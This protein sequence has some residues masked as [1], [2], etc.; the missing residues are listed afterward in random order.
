MSNATRDWWR[1]RATQAAQHA[2]TCDLSLTPVELGNPCGSYA[3]LSLAGMDGEPIRARLVKPAGEGPHPVILMFHDANRGVRGWHHMTRF[4]ALGY[5]VAALQNRAG[6]KDVLAPEPLAVGDGLGV[7]MRVP[8]CPEPIPVGRELAPAAADAFEATLDDALV[9]AGVLS[10]LEGF[11]ATEV[12]TWGEGLGA[13]LALSVAS[14]VAARA[15]CALNPLP[16][17]LAETSARA[18][19]ALIA[20]GLACP[21]LMGTCAL[22]LQASRQAQDALAAGL[23]DVRRIVYPRYGH[24]RVNAF[25]DEMLSFLVGLQDGRP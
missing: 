7:A 5:A 9:L 22:D 25:E 16:A 3:E 10:R 18:D 8:T 2:G 15:A 24:E 13:G 17:A 20:Q 21:V 4:V 23:A 1:D 19:V 11:D 12:V 14:L 6:V